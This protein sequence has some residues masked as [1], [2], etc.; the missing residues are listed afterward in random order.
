MKKN[1]L[2]VILLICLSLFTGCNSKEQKVLTCTRNATITDGVKME[3]TY[4][5]T[6]T[7]DYVDVIETEEKIIA[8]NTSI[9]ESYKTSIESIYSPYKNI[10]YYSYDVTISGNTLTSTTK[11]DYANI[12]TDKLIEID[13]ANATLIKDGKVRIDDVKALYES[14]S[15]G[16][17]CK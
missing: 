2:L 16:A 12:D 10:E 1:F 4:K 15:V 6:Y 9:L 11:I 5:A 17:I 7:G 3:L 14:S 13:S 8:D